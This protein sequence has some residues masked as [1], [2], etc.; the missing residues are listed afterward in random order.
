MCY[1]TVNGHSHNMGYYL[2][3][4]IY[5]LWVAFVKTIF[6]PHCNK[7]SQFVAMQEATRN[8]V[9][10]GNRSAPSSFGYCSWSCN[11]VRIRDFV[12]ADDMLCHFA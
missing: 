5:P 12:A 10:R 4:G 3:D 2:A 7:Q 6:D 1:Y 9:E 11:Y 8:N